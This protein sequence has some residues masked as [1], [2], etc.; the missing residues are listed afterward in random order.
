MRTN[1]ST[2]L[3]L[4]ALL[5]GT[6]LLLPT[7]AIAAAL[8]SPL[9]LSPL[10]E[11]ALTQNPVLQAESKSSKRPC[12]RILLLAYNSGISHRMAIWRRAQVERKIRS[13]RWRRDFPSL[14]SC[15]SRERLQAA[16]RPSANKPFDF[17]NWT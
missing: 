3:A 5:V 12:Y 9:E 11:E 15:R 16:P 13:T 17:K 2:T 6:T 10:I 1:H 8:G 14:V 4:T 7:G